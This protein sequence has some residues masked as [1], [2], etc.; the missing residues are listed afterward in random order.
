VP[1]SVGSEAQLL[2]GT[3]AAGSVGIIGGVLLLDLA[4]EE[5]VK[6]ETDINVICTGDA[7]SWRSR[8]QPRASTKLDALLGQVPQPGRLGVAVG[9]EEAGQLG[10]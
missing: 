8:A 9:D 6:A 3:V 4:Y 1:D 10:P 2:T 5:D 7:A